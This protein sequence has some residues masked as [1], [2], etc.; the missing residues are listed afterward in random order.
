LAGIAVAGCG[1]GD[2]PELPTPDPYFAPGQGQLP[3]GTIAYA[4]G[5]YG[6]GKGA[7]IA[8]YQFVGY[9]NK[10]TNATACDGEPCGL[11]VIQLADFYN[12]HYGD[13]TYEPKDEA[14][15]DRL[16]PPDSIYEPGKPK[17]HVL[18]VNV[19]AVWC[20]PCKAEAHDTFPG[21]HAKYKPRGGEFLVQLGD[22]GTPGIPATQSDLDNWTSQFKV[23]YPAAI[24]PSLKLAGLFDSGTYPDNLMIRTRTMEIVD[25]VAGQ[26]EEGGAFWQAFEHEL[27]Q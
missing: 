7:I 17:P 16:F 15:D 6:I 26:A 20:G 8:N 13:S 24:D 1:G 5:P 10:Q 3:N 22:S 27:D 14:S 18:L 4:P 23:D 21:L 12:P 11:Q 25:L 19:S 9:A 2:A